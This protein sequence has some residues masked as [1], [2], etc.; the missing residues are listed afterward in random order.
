MNKHSALPHIAN[1]KKKEGEGA[2]L[3]SFFRPCDLGETYP[4]G[5]LAAPAFAPE[6]STRI[7]PD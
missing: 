3:L 4:I 2:E 5:V 6:T 1:K 7:T